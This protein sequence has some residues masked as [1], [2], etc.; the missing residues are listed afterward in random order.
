LNSAEWLDESV[1]RNEWRGPLHGVPVVIEDLFD[2]LVGVPNTFGCVAT[3]DY[4]PNSTAVH[5]QG[6]IDAGAVIIG[7]TNQFSRFSPIRLL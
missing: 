4:V 1:T 2:P 3:R 5:V 6:V 7:K